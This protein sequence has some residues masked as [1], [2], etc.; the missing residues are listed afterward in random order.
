MRA[1]P[2]VLVLG[3]GCLAAATVGLAWFIDH[4]GR[5]D[6]AAEAHVYP[7][8]PHA[9]VVLGARVDP[10]GQPSPT[11]R[12]RVAH[13]VKAFPASGATVLVF[14]GGVGRHGRAEAEVARDLAVALGATAALCLVETDSH[15][16]QENARF[17]MRLLQQRFGR[18]RLGV[19]LVSDPYHLLR[20]GLLFEREG[21]V[22]G[23]S[24]VLDA[25]RHV[26]P[27]ARAAWTLR[28][29]P[30]TLKDV[31][32]AAWRAPSSGASPR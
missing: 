21:A 6:A 20:A 9:M 24:P 26:D 30:A 18:E 14:S 17:T 16:T 29:V 23:T 22:V 2:R 1:L 31:V 28:E 10:D 12:A 11:L 27:V 7:D 19:V 32:S 13:A 3:C 5:V 25:P 8:G 15:S 4:A